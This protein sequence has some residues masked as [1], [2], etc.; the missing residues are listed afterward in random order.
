MQPTG[1]K[2]LEVIFRTQNQRE[3]WGQAISTFHKKS[4]AA[5]IEISKRWFGR[6]VTLEDTVTGIKQIRREL[7]RE[8]VKNLQGKNVLTQPEG[9]VV[10]KHLLY[11][12]NKDGI[13][14]GMLRCSDRGVE[15][16][17]LWPLR[18]CLLIIV[19]GKFK[20]PATKGARLNAKYTREEERYLEPALEKLQRKFAE[21]ELKK[22]DLSQVSREADAI[23]PTLEIS[24]LLKELAEGKRSLMEFVAQLPK[25]ETLHAEL[26]RLVESPDYVA[27]THL[28]RFLGKLGSFLGDLQSE[29]KYVQ[30]IREQLAALGERTRVYGGHVQPSEQIDP[31]MLQNLMACCSCSS[32]MNIYGYLPV[33]RALSVST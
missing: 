19:Q 31:A 25:K 10:L 30:S 9:A 20:D 22:F 16:V 2:P 5:D 11:K 12:A 6:R 32:E 17:S 29:V 21:T 18:K 1:I 28:W 23:D 14:E 3:D 24:K 13:S 8:M 4:L 27:S 26:V 33:L 15:L 7:L